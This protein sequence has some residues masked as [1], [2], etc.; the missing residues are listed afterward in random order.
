MASLVI[1]KWVPTHGT[2]FIS[3]VCQLNPAQG[4]T[5]RP[6]WV[7]PVRMSTIIW[8]QAIKESAIEFDKVSSITFIGIIEMQFTEA[9]AVL[10]M[11]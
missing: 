11:A 2:Y 8:L 5:A 6:L 9:R 1:H 3:R 10:S 7:R 4:D